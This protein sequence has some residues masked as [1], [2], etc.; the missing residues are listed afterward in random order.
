MRDRG[1]HA[2]RGSASANQ[3]TVRRSSESSRSVPFP[4]N[5]TEGELSSEANVAR[6]FERQARRSPDAVAVMF[7]ADRLSYTELDERSNRLARVLRRRGVAPGI[8]AGVSLERS[9]HAPI[10]VLAILK[11]GGAYVAL[12][13][14]Y[15]R[16][17][18]AFML[19]DSNAPIVLTDRATAANLPV[20][21]ARTLALDSAPVLESMAAEDRGPLEGGADREDLAYVL[22]T[23]GSTGRPK[24][25]A[26]PHRALLNLIEWQIHEARNAAAKTLQFASLNFDVSFQE[27]FSTWCAGGILQLVSEEL[28][29]NPAALWRHIREESIERLFLPFIALQ[30]LA[31]AAEDVHGEAPLLRDV[32]TAGEQLQI[33]PQIR[34]FFE[35]PGRLLHNHY[36]PSETHVV[37]A[38]TLEGPAS[39]W[40][41]LPPIGR[42]IRNARVYLLDPE[43]QPVASGSPGEIYIGGEG[44]AVGYWKRPELTAERFV[45]DS[46]QQGDHSRLYRT[47]DLGRCDADGQ[48]EFLGRL[49]DQAKIRGFR[50]EPGEVSAALAQHPAVAESVVVVR[51]DQH[52]DKILAAYVVFRPGQ[53]A[54]SPELRSFLKSKLPEYMV[55]SFFVSLPSLPLTPSGKVDR[56][57]LPEPQAQREA[58]NEFDRPRDDWEM[59]LVRIWESVFRIERVGIHD[60]FFELGGHSLTAGRLFAQI[61]NQFGRDL[62]PTTLLRAPTI[63]ELAAFVRSERSPL[64]WKSLVPIQARGTRPPL[65]CMHAGAGTILYYQELARL[66]GPDQPIY[67]LQAQGLYGD[68]PPH[69]D[70]EEM[71][72]HYAREI[73]TVQPE[74]PYH[75]AGFC[76]GGLLAFAVAQRLRMEGNEI[77]L[78]ASFDGGSHTFDYAVNTGDAADQ[79]RLSHLSQ[80][81]R[82]L[83]TAEKLVYLGRKGRNRVRL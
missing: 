64:R 14:A 82:R 4:W 6:L 47:G 75:L 20:V 72:A 70:I 34:R 71:A 58:D 29:R 23:S 50:V 39:Q 13:P 40:P 78:L 66:L 79:G 44:V 28:R 49:D 61:R 55:P 38:F 63:A 54:R 57:A 73:R 16:E 22:Y 27:M 24:G 56:R 18:I 62:P 69:A 25:V 77:G 7:G 12:D 81:L 3:R 19:E 8:L 35:T 74:G 30:Q 67:G 31:E 1:L 26:M 45:P 48:I 21:P 68:A 60:D 9:I 33:T 83:G 42:P 2:I 65:F 11:A 36:G 53:T 41:A 10:A 5:D 51:E 37:T 59:Q 43:R 17:R 15:P 52:R 32:I 76:F 80:E 46:F